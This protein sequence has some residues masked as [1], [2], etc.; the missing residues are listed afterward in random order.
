L[1][2]GDQGPNT[3]GMGV[4]AP[5]PNISTEQIDEW[6]Q[7]ILQPTI[8]GLRAEG[9]PFVGVLYAGLMLTHT[10]PKVL[11]FNCRFGDPETQVLMPLLKTDLTKI[12]SACTT[13]QLETCEIEWAD[14]TAICV[15]L[16]AK[17]YPETPQ[18]GDIINGLETTDLPGPPVETVLV[19]NQTSVTNL[20][21][22]QTVKKDLDSYVVEHPATVFHAGTKWQANQ[23]VTAGGRVLAVTAWSNNLSNAKQ[24][25]Y[26]HVKNITFDGMQY[27]HD[28]GN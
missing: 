5:V 24:L 6:T 2:D 19:K 15:I 18:T 10:G 23:L 7:T 12:I 26:A 4:Y 21:D 1:L 8:D 22:L 9:K 3:G 16:A 28:I 27:R 20:H 14:Q 13:Q 17:N 25:A 11:E